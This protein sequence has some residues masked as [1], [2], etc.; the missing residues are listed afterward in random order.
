[1]S[2][3][4]VRAPAL[5]SDPGYHGLKQYLLEWTGLA[6]YL[7][8][9]D[10]LA[11]KIARRLAACKLSGCTAYLALLRD[12]VEGAAELDELV[13]DLTIGET[14]FFRFEEHFQALRTAIIPQLIRR[15]A[16][17]RQLR[18]WSAGCSFGAEP[19]SLTLMLQREFAGELAGW[20]VSVIGTDINRQFLAR[21]RQACFGEWTLRGVDA[22]LR[23]T[24]FELTPQ[25][26]RLLDA[27][28]QGVSFQYHNLVK[29][30]YPSLSHNLTGFDLILCRNVLIYFSRETIDQCLARFWSSLVEGGWLLVG[31]AES[32]P[33]AFGA[34]QAVEFPGALAFQRPLRGGS[35]GPQAGPP[36]W[37]NFGKPPAEAVADSATTDQTGWSWAPTAPPWLPAPLPP[38]PS[39]PPPSPNAARTARI[40]ELADRAQWAEA[41]EVCRRLIE[42]DRLDPLGH[43]YQALVLEQTGDHRGADEALSRAIYLD[44]Y[45][46]LAH[47]HRGLLLQKGQDL[48]GAARS[49]RNVLD[50]LVSL[51]P[52]TMLAEG[53]GISA[54][55]LRELAQ[56]NLDVLGAPR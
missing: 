25:G 5:T 34:F 7:D 49:F 40:R 47:Y 9:D 37:G 44:R 27:Y 52:D 30:P 33:E 53:D 23:S 10:Q 26:H 51:E 21:A 29:H 15:N 12:G 18:I 38:P 54:S 50:L 41:S 35:E 28:R 43:F 3:P 55:A 48:A 1:V 42:A 32:N 31:H 4:A 2:L 24:C 56:M 39:S 6:F 14:H 8:K 11:E 46:V 16:A 20:D 45:F 19:Y 13:G 36:D 22:R 17:R